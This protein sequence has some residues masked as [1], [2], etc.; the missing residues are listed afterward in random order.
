VQQS[1][2]LPTYRPHPDPLP[3]QREREDCNSVQDFHAQQ[4]RASF[5]A[6]IRIETTL[7]GYREV[8]I[9]CARIGF[10][11]PRGPCR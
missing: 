7:S 3:Q 8:M 11:P 2:R 9:L 10:S 1:R 6:M 4:R 5:A